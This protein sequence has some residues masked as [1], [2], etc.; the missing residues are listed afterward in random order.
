M[1]GRRTGQ[2]GLFEGDHL[3]L[4]HV[5]RNSFYGFIALHRGLLF[6]DHDFAEVAPSAGG[7]PSVPPSLLATALVLQLHDGVS[8]D[9]ARQRAC[10]DA[11]WK[12]ALGLEMESKPFST[13]TLRAF[14]LQVLA[15]ER[16]RRA[17]ARGLAFVQQRGFMSAGGPYRGSPA[18][19]PAPASPPDA[20]AG[21]K[22][23]ANGGQRPRPRLQ[24]TEAAW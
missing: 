22:F 12:V 19:P 23:D 10:F 15:S 18:E 2:L 11:R 20:A 21:G 6:N 5:G 13:S 24:L 1:L 8:D 7:R 16:M 14:R 9:E 3:W 4:D 17:L